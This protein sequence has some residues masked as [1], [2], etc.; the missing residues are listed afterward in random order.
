MKRQ[1]Q[2][3]IRILLLTAVIQF[4]GCNREKAEHPEQAEVPQVEV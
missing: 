1:M 2:T 3:F 4:V